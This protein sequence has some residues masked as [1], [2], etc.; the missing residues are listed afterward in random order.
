MKRRLKIAALILGA[1]ILVLLS[2]LAWIINTESGLRFA[3]ARL[4]EK[5]GKVTLHIEDVRGTIAGASAPGW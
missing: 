2:F 4:P 1:L 3:V 5:M